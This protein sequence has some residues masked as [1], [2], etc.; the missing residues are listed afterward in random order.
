M[1]LQSCTEYH[2]IFE[3]A[4][5]LYMKKEILNA[6][7]V[8][9]DALSLGA[10]AAVICTVGMPVLTIFLMYPVSTDEMIW[11]DTSV[12]L[13]ILAIIQIVNLVGK[14]SREIYKE[15][16]DFVRDTRAKGNF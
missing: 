12:V 13:C 6:V 10:L 8:V 1:C 7:T 14:F 9:V 16:R 3:P 11:Y 15:I 5:N 2:S 4:E